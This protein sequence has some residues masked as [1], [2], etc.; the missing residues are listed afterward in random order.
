M[1]LQQK[2]CLLDVN[3]VCISQGDYSHGGMEGGDGGEVRWRTFHE[4]SALW[5]T[6]I[7]MFFEFVKH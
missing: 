3:D 7:Y 5:S 1:D 2:V 4:N 6:S